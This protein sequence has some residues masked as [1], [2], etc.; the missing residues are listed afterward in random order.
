MNT[1]KY[2][3]PAD[4]AYCGL[5]CKSFQIGY[6]KEH[7]KET[8]SEVERFR[9]LDTKLIEVHETEKGFWVEFKIPCKHLFNG[10]KGY[11]CDIY[12]KVRPK[13]CEEYPYANTLDCP[14]KKE[15]KTKM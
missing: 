11:Y 14:N 8:L 3:N 2:I 9:L 10:E 7:D 12:D 13:L 5:C 6:S 15:I 1:S 4:C